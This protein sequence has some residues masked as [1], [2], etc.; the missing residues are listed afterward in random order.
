MK[1]AGE[2]NENRPADED[3]IP[4]SSF[5]PGM[6]GI[7]EQIGRYKLLRILGEGGFGIVYWRSSNAR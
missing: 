7:G 2:K 6:V 3:S 1:D 5:G 4:T